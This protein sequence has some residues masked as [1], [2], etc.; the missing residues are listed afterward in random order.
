MIIG[1][2]LDC[3]LNNMD[4]VW[5]QRYNQDYNDQLTIQDIKTWGIDKIVKPD[6][7]KQIYAYWKEPGF[8]RNLSVQPNAKDVM[9]RL[10]E[11]HNHEVFIVTASDPD[12]MMDKHD[13]IKEHLPFFDLDRLVMLKHKWRMEL[14][15]LIDDGLHN[16][17]LN[18]KFWL[19]FH[20]AHNASFV[21]NE[22]NTFRMHNW[23]E[24]ERFFQGK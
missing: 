12:V 16:F 19:V 11:N 24:I 3:V 15:V 9:K 7:G 14:D 1:V 21:C 8:F 13:W 10:C 2:D 22:K 5:I 6:C 17:G 23:N 18:H 20:K 4:E